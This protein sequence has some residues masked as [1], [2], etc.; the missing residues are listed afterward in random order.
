MFRA[1]MKP[2]SRK[3]E[4]RHALFPN[5][6]LFYVLFASCRSMY[7]SCVNV[8]CTTAT[9]W[10]HNCSLTN[11]SYHI[12]SYHQKVRHMHKGIQSTNFS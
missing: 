7:C 5:F 1:T 6:V 8:Y 11:I 12:I 9:G 10:L 3:D 4:A 2:S